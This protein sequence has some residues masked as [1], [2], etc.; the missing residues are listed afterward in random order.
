M[1]G[2]ELFARNLTSNADAIGNQVLQFQQSH[3]YDANK[4]SKDHD[5]QQ[6]EQAAKRSKLT[7]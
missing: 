2:L 4:R 7:K 1:P 3:L 5:K 6:E